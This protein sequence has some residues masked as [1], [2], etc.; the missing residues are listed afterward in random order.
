MINASF[1][2][3]DKAFYQSRFSGVLP[4]E[5]L[6]VGSKK[7]RILIE[8]YNSKTWVSVSRLVLFSELPPKN[9]RPSLRLMR[10]TKP[11]NLILPQEN[12]P[13]LEEQ[14]NK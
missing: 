7:I 6:E 8:G 2:M 4:C 1:K 10:K 11:E 5:I 14:H 13:A 3:S 12:L 9:D